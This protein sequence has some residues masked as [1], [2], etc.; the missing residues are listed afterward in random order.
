[1]AVQCSKCGARFTNAYQ[2]GPHVRCCQIGWTGISDS[3]FSDDSDPPQLAQN[4]ND[5]DPSAELPESQLAQR[6]TA[7][8]GS[9]SDLDPHSVHLSQLAQ[10]EV[11]TA[12]VTT[13]VKLINP[14]RIQH[15]PDMTV[16]YVAIQKMWRLYVHTVSGLCS[17]QFWSLFQ[18]VNGEKGACADAVL[19]WTKHL[20]RAQPQVLLSS[21]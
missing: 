6:Q 8:S 5:S 19:K 18:V 14:L 21:R 3:S 10:R 13:P 1:M 11:H 2:L 7:D 16:A 20:L 9:Q 15:N 4:D 12:G 17:D